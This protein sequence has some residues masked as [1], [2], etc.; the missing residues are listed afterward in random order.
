MVRIRLTGGESWKNGLLSQKDFVPPELG[1]GPWLLLWEA[2]NFST[3]KYDIQMAGS[4]KRC[5][6]LGVE[7]VNGLGDSQRQP[8]KT[9]AYPVHSSMVSANQKKINI[10]RD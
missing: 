1:V 2:L 5:G 9:C 3:V 7:C 10:F 8:Q 6:L 4:A